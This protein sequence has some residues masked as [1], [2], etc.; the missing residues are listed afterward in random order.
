MSYRDALGDKVNITATRTTCLD[1]EVWVYVD[2]TSL[3]ITVN[4]PASPQ[5]NQ[6]HYVIDINGNANTNNITVSGNGNNINGS[7]SDTIT[8]NYQSQAYV[9]NGAQWNKI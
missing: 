8:V 2:S 9:Y 5:T 7:A 1:N 4:L 3:A 6:R